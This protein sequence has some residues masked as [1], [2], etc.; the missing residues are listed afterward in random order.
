MLANGT[1]VKASANEN[2]VLGV[3]RRRR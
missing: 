3:K 1:V 2:V